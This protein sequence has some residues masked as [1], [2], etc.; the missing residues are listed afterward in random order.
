MSAWAAH[1]ASVIASGCA[2]P[3]GFF[4]ILS[5]SVLCKSPSGAHTKKLGLP[6]IEGAPTGC[7]GLRGWSGLDRSDPEEPQLL[8][9]HHYRLVLVLVPSGWLCAVAL[10][11]VGHRQLAGWLQLLR[12]LLAAFRGIAPSPAKGS[13]TRGCVPGK[14]PSPS[15]AEMRLMGRSTSMRRLG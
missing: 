2:R 4:S 6:R 3:R 11:W 14:P 7:S 1:T 9:L 12:D 10:E 13:T 5:S 8:L 15:W